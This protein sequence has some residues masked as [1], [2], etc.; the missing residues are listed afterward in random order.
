[1]ATDCY[2][3]LVIRHP[4][5]EK[6]KEA[7]LAFKNGNLLQYFSPMEEQPAYATTWDAWDTNGDIYDM[8]Q[9]DHVTLNDIQKDNDAYELHLWFC[10]A[11]GPPTNALNT[12]VDKGFTID[13]TWHLETNELFGTQKNKI[14]VEKQGNLVEDNGDIDVD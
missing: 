7:Y 5:K 1:M 12:A 3:S 8:E 4:E 14:C 10:T 13:L 11:W 9:S 2:C 6:V